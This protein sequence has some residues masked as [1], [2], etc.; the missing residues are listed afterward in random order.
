MKQNTANSPITP[1]SKDVF[2]RF[3]KR[4]LQLLCKPVTHERVN[5]VVARAKASELDSLRII[6]LLSIAVTPLNRNVRISIGV[7]EDVEG[8]VTTE[9]GK[10]GNRG[11]DLAEDGGDF[12]L[13]LFLG[14]FRGGFTGIGAMA[15]YRISSW[16][17]D[18][19]LLRRWDEDSDDVP[20]GLVF[21]IG[22]FEGGP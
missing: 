18:N 11:G 3:L 8:T 4:R 19:S 1:I 10:E 6:D 13:D 5:S 20:W 22:G 21:L 14:L 15:G 2:V 17:L 7:D 12:I 16:P 9:L